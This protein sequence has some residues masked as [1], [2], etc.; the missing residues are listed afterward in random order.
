MTIL[1][2]KKRELSIWLYLIP[3]KRLW[4]YPNEVV[5]LHIKNDQF[6]H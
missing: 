2:I 6:K 5:Q 4:Y 1:E 3:N